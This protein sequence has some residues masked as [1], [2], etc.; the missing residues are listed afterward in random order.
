[1]YRPKADPATPTTK[2]GQISRLYLTCKNKITVQAG[3]PKKGMM[4]TNKA[5]KKTN[6]KYSI[7]IVRRKDFTIYAKITFNCR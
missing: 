6:T 5:A 2:Q 4:S 1:M 7:T 3:G